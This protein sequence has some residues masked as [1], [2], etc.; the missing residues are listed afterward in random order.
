MPASYWSSVTILC[1]DSGLA[2]ALSTALFLLPQ[3]EGQKI[4]A[5]CGAEAMWVDS[6]GRCYYSPGFREHIRT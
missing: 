3:T 2:D 5:E 1:D 6:A 4:L